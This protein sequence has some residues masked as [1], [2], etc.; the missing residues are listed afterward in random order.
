MEALTS[1]DLPYFQASA[2]KRGCGLVAVINVDEL[3]EM[4]GAYS[5]KKRRAHND[6]GRIDGFLRAAFCHGCQQHRVRGQRSW[7]QAWPQSP[8]SDKEASKETKEAKPSPLP[9]QPLKKRRRGAGGWQKQAWQAC[10]AT[11]AEE[12]W[13]TQAYRMRVQQ[14]MQAQRAKQPANRPCQEQ[15]AWRDVR[16]QEREALLHSLP[17]GAMIGPPLPWHSADAQTIASGTA[18]VLLRDQGDQGE[19]QGGQVDVR[20]S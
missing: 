15:Q 9:T 18:Q 14:T 1:S 19:R 16:Q 8:A 11:P 5:K 10:R 4:E 12:K 20:T 7:T 3:Q 6:S 2:T 17:D 13:N